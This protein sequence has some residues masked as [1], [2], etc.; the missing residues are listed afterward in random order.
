MQIFV[1]FIGPDD[2]YRASEAC[3]VAPSLPLAVL[4]S[5]AF[6]EASS[7]GESG[8]TRLFHVEGSR[9]VADT[10]AAAAGVEERDS[11][12]VVHSVDGTFP[13]PSEL[14]VRWSAAGGVARRLVVMPPPAPREWQREPQLVP[15]LEIDHISGELA[16]TKPRSR[17]RSSRK[18]RPS[19]CQPGG[20]LRFR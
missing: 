18:P 6:L 19:V 13:S 11:L 9:Y 3:F 1:D 8:P 12:V 10:S 15:G 14:R 2:R 16:R 5:D 20:P 7:R 17:E 4:R